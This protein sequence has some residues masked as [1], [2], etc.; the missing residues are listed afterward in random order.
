MATFETDH[1]VDMSKLTFTKFDPTKFATYTSVTATP[2]SIDYY[3]YYDYS[4]V[5]WEEYIHLHD[6][7]SGDFSYVYDTNSNIVDVNGLVNSIEFSDFHDAIGGWQK[8]WSIDDISID[9][10]EFENGTSGAILALIFAGADTIR[11]SVGGDRLYGYAGDDLIYGNG[12]ND[13][14]RGGL[15]ADIMVGGSGN[16]TYYV[17]NAFDGVVEFIGGGTDIVHSEINYTLGLAVDHL[18]LSGSAISGTG[19]DLANEITGNDG[20]NVLDGRDGNDQLYGGGGNDR[21]I[22][23]NGADYLEGAGGLD[24]ADY[25]ASASGLTVNITLPSQNTGEAKGDRYLSIENVIGTKYNDTVAGDGSANFIQG[26]SGHDILYGEGGNDTLNGDGGNDIIFGG[27]GADKFNGGA[28]IDTAMY[29]SASARI[30]VSLANPSINTGDAAG[31]S[32]DL[33]ENVTGSRFGDYVF[34][35]NKTN[36]LDGGAGN[37]ILKS[38]NGNDTLIGNT[39]DD[40]FVF[41]SALN[42]ATNID[43][44]QDFNIA[45]DAIWLDNAIFKALKDG[46]L[47]SSAFRIGSA[48]ADASDRIIYDKTTGKLSYD[49]D[50]AG[51]STGIQ[52]AL[53]SKNLAL[54]SADFI[55]V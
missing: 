2:S 22:G 18:F 27:N 5:D 6:I 44:I 30:T 8:G 15:G 53:L 49:I 38:Y 37:D 46:A 40:V 54:T 16:T 29:S 47:A 7:Y 43:V 48:A 20:D 25:S 23:R 13:V 17:D 42:A 9:V 31:D 50:G 45:D 24:T 14:I 10:S 39:G 36:V 26:G 34:G 28:G 33:I 11:G 1:A 52:F 19:N 41:N 12:G 55:V 21:L 3:R 35:D 32:F 51:G 4:D